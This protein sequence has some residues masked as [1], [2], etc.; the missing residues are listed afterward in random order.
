[1]PEPDYQETFASAQERLQRGDARGALEAFL[2]VAAYPGRLGDDPQRWRESLEFVARVGEEAVG[3]EF[4]AAARAAAD[5]VDDPQL[6]FELG[7]ELID[8]GVPG[9]AAT[10]LSRAND[11]APHE[12][13]I[14]SE[15]C[16]ALER[17]LRCD[18][19][20]EVLRESPELIE[21]DPACR[22]L[23]AYH[24]LMTGDLDEPR[25]LLPSLEAGHEE[26]QLEAAA[27]L[28]GMLVRADAVR[29]A[30]PLDRHD[31]RGWH[32]VV[33]GGMLLHLSPSPDDA[34]RGRYHGA[35]DS[36]A[37]CLEGLRR[38]QVVLEAWSVRSPRIWTPSDPDGAVLADAAGKLF[39][40]PVRN[41]PEEG[42]DEPGLIVAY[43]L[44][45]WSEEAL[46]SF[47]EH[48]PG[49]I[50]WTHSTCWIEEPPFASDLTTYLHQVNVSPWGRRSGPEGAA[51]APANSSL[52]ADLR[53][54][55][56]LSAEVLAAPLAE[57]ALADLPALLALAQAAAS[58]KG[59]HAAGA[60]RKSGPRRPQPTA[61]PVPAQRP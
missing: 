27:R 18:D 32:F 15:L 20:L 19:A 11:L 16:C 25:R 49:Q 3:E 17:D 30:T 28:R 58:I 8:V 52:P 40:V 55:E 7:F 1:M 42:S 6:L 56:V 44:D 39:G 26:D 61:S 33:S 57:N 23:A 12:A 45:R 9:L 29:G 41:W 35:M 53:P 48:R 60:F 14:V 46:E 43:D 5:D 4:A 37:R 34:L 21:S 13:A 54:T 22:F 2:E 51:T 47:C 36:V 38:L 50:L 59:D 31:L 24:S 10:V